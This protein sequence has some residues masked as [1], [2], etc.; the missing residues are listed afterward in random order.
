MSPIERA[1]CHRTIGSAS[2]VSLSKS[3]K[4]ARPCPRS[5]PIASVALT[6]ASGFVA[7]ESCSRSSFMFSGRVSICSVDDEAAAGLPSA[8]NIAASCEPS[9]SSSTSTGSSEVVL[10][11]LV[12]GE[13]ATFWVATTSFPSTTS[14][15][16]TGVV[17]DSCLG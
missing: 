14:V 1:A 6:T 5:L 16:M 3:D 17:S 12:P 13:V 2:A 15:R 9:A 4:A 8:D 11:S 10:I 7:A